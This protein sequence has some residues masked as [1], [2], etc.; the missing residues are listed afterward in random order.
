E[1]YVIFLFFTI[2]VLFLNRFI[3]SFKIP[4]I[5]INIIMYA[6]ILLACSS[7][8]NLHI[9]FPIIIII[10]VNMLVKKYISNRSLIFIFL[11][12]KAKKIPIGILSKLEDIVNKRVNIKFTCFTPFYLLY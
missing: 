4:C 7:V 9:I 2:F 5:P 3:N 1:R 10:R 8:I 12:F 6:P 11:L